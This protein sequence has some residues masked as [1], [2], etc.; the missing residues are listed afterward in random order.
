MKP[1]AFF[2]TIALAALTALFVVQVGT[3]NANTMGARGKVSGLYPVILQVPT[4]MVQ[5]VQPRGARPA[6]RAGRQITS[7]PAAPSPKVGRVGLKTI[8][9]RKHYD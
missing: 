9:F 6:P 2:V 4:T 3:A 1:S 7:A 8:K 5:P